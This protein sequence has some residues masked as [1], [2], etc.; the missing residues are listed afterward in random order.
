MALAMA[1]PAVLSSTAAA[2]DKTFRLEALVTDAT[3][4]PDASMEVTE[5]WTYRFE[6]GPFNFGIRS[7]EQNTDQITDLTAS[8]EQGP[9]T[10]IA[11]D[12]SVSGDWEWQLREPTSDRTVTFTVGYRVVDA[13]RVGADVADLNWKFLGSEHPGVGDVRITVRM[14]GSI[15]PYVEGLPD[16]DATVL[17]GWAHGPTTGTVEVGASTVVA[18]VTDVPA[19]QFVEIR[20]AVPVTVFSVTGEATLLPDI[21][22]QERGLIETSPDTGP[23]RTWLA[24]L[25]TPIIAALGALGAGLLWRRYGREP[26]ST[27]VLG[28]YW[29]E[30]LD[31]PPAIAVS[32]LGR[33]KADPGRMIAGTLTDLAQR[34]FLSITAQQLQRR[35]PDTT[36]HHY[37]WRGKPTDSLHPFER[38]LLQMVFRGNTTA[39]SV[40]LTAWAQSN[41]TQAKGMI[42]AMTADVRRLYNERGYDADTNGRAFG[43]LAI[44]ALAMAAGSAVLAMF[45]KSGIAWFGV[46]AALVTLAVGATVLRNRSQAG[47]EA[48][49]KAAGLK[50]Y[51]KDFSQLADAPVGHLI[52]WER[53][54]V[55]SVAFGVSAELMRG[56]AVRLPQVMNDPTFTTWYIGAGVHRFDGFSSIGTQTAAVVAA[57]I[58]NS[59]GAG[60]GFSGGGSS[61]GGGGGGAGAR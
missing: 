22:A 4:L 18:A 35:G 41:R 12:E 52:L 33:G 55:Y 49:A 9:L 23:D 17:R 27:E 61:G 14:P 45:S 29:R 38:Q 59:S 44:L 20:A 37:Q 40:E 32:T 10:V 30:P 51:I 53:F 34:G 15:E 25:F 11:P 42:D 46:A 47:A 39:D 31:D 48:Y 24:R 50:R 13:L 36:V 57:A 54:L 56:L 8:D 3:V 43:M 1:A 21:L 58:P 2:A 7:F 6:G 19:G 28:D 16:D 26:R 60:G 5:R